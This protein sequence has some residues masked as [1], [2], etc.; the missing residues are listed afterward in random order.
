MASPKFPATILAISLL[1]L[2]SQPAYCQTCKTQTFSNKK[3]FQN[4][5]D[6]PYLNAYL[7]WTY[8]EVK[9][10]LSMG[11]IA[12]PAQTG[13]WI[14]WGINPNGTHMLGSQALVA[15]K[16]SNGTATANK[17]QLISYSN[18]QEGPL[19]FNVS[20]LS[21]GSSGQ[22]LMIFATWT[23][24][25]GTTVNQIWQTGPGVSNGKP[26]PHATTGDHLK[27]FGVLKLT[28]T[29]AAPGGGPVGAPE[30]TG[31]VSGGG[32][33][34]ATPSDGGKSLMKSVG[35]YGVLLLGGLSFMF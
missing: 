11:F 22:N 13:G 12:P 16:Q 2:L 7:H 20:D 15:F 31:S 9:S 1:F 27:S 17:F 3:T 34:Q 30:P 19:T 28:Q 4:C 8:D 21:A 29:A 6:L 32:T 33:P 10:S 23:L 35:F 18:I 26:Q 24:P 25:T 14:G 5:L